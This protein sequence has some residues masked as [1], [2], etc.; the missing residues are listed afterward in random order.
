MVA[1]D[2]FDPDICVTLCNVCSGKKDGA[3]GGTRTS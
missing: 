1:V 2:P 3:R